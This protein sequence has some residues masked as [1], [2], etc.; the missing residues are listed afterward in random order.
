MARGFSSERAGS[1]IE[2]CVPSSPRATLVDKR[3]AQ[4]LR[5]ISFGSPI[6]WALPGGLLS[7]TISKVGSKASALALPI[8]S[9][10]FPWPPRWLNPSF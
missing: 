3:N 2:Q 8:G 5:V 7:E 9:G 10:V 1:C 4:E 6:A